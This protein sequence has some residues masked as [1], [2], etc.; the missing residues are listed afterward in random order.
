M[1]VMAGI[2]FLQEIWIEIRYFFV[3]TCGINFL[4]IVIFSVF[5]TSLSTLDGSLSQHGASMGCG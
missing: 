4:N 5:G 2:T 1:K 3:I